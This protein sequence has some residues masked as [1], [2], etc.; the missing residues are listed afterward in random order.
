MN[1]ACGGWRCLTKGVDM[2]HDIV[3]ATSFLFLSDFE[4]RVLDFDVCFHLGYGFLRYRKTELFYVSMKLFELLRHDQNVP[5]SASASHTHSFRQ[6]EKRVRGE[7]S[8]FIS[9][10]A[11]RELKGVW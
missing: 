4:F 11:Y 1:D 6:V 10:L 2:G 9:L 8:V 7:K 3:T 5:F